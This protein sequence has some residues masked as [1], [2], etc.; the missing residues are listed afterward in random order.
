MKIYNVTS[1]E[2][3]ERISRHCPEALS[4]YL[5]CINRANEKGEIFFTKE[6]IDIDLS[7]NFGEFKKN[8]KKLARE[9]LL[10][11]VPLNKGIFVMLVLDVDDE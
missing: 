2:T 5:Q 11:W 9:N 1:Q 8:I 10:S 6:M 4:V 7:E 3:L